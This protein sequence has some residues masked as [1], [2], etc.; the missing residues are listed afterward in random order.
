M[1]NCSTCEQLSRDLLQLAYEHLRA[2]QRLVELTFSSKDAVKTS[3]AAM[4]AHSLLR[5]RAELIAV[6]NTHRDGEHGTDRTPSV[7][8]ALKLSLLPRSL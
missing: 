8:R 7:Q 5:K 6:M 3:A 1:K 4:T 2:E